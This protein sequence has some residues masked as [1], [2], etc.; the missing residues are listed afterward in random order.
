[1]T[2]EQISPFL[3]SS[4]SAHTAAGLVPLI[5]TEAAELPRRGLPEQ[6]RTP[7]S[8]IF[9]GPAELVLSEGNYT[10][11]HEHLGQV[12]WYVWPIAPSLPA[13]AGEAGKQRYQVSFS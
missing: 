6:F 4:F 9:S 3:N 10:L 1:M 11:D 8:L 2:L 13:K 5:L 12:S 7:L